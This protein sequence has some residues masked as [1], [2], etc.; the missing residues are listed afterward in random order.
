MFDH[1]DR[2][3]YHAVWGD[4]LGV[5]AMPTVFIYSLPIRKPSR[6]L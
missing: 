2:H 6:H 3:S 5:V 1:Y 4:R